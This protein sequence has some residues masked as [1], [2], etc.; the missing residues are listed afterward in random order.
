MVQ[1]EGPLQPL[2]HSRTPQLPHLSQGLLSLPFK[3]LGQGQACVRCGH[4]VGLNQALDEPRVLVPILSP[5][6]WGAVQL[7]KG[8]PGLRGQGRGPR[9]PRVLKTCLVQ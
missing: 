1:T 2:T 9:H 4:S 6:T 3:G 5:P 7:P 8:A